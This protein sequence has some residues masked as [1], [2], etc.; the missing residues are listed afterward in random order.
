MYIHVT[1][2]LVLMSICLG[3]PGVQ[4][5]NMNTGDFSFASALNMLIVDIFLY[6][7]L[8]WYLGE[9]RCLHSYRVAFLFSLG[10]LA[11]SCYAVVLLLTYVYVC[12]VCMYVLC[13]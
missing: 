2:L 4:Y 1:V 8:A 7:L 3:L 13:R 9:V 10:R 5:Y 12:A 11:L 6:T